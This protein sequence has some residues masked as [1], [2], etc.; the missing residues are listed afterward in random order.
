[1]R[2]FT[3]AGP[4]RPRGR[5][6]LG[7]VRSALLE[8]FYEHRRDLAF[9]RTSDPWAVLVSEVMAQQTQAARAAEA[10]SRFLVAFPTPTALAAASPA[11]VLRAWRGLGYNRRAL[12]LQAAARA[13]VAD[14]GGAVPADLDALE[15][16]PGVGPYTARAVAAIAFGLPVIGLDT[17]VRR[18]LSR[19]FF[20][21]TPATDHLQRFADSLV[22]DERAADW[23]HALMDLGATI[24]TARLPGCA[25]CPLQGVCRFA[26][27]A[28][29]RR[30][31]VTGRPPRRASPPFPLTNRWLRG[32]ILDRLRDEVDGAWQAFDGPIGAHDHAAVR[33]ALRAL[34]AE[35]L[36]EVDGRSFALARLP[37]GATN[38]GGPAEP[39][40]ASGPVGP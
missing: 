29:P 33:A 1:V 28:A 32:R 17:N 11:A 7:G 9:R 27:A 26:G 21:R 25:E 16:L 8:W 3:A 14:H 6:T 31:A 36:I 37:P 5:W 35:G 13:I 23:S 30:R 10:W 19:A 39:A 4:A 20:D 24:C 40:A 12:A 2:R 18:V 34:A 22:P 38:P 15:R